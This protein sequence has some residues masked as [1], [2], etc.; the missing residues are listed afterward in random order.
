M[1]TFNIDDVFRNR[2]QGIRIRLSNSKG[3]AA[4]RRER[5]E[6]ASSPAARASV[7]RTKRGSPAT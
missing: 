1:E 7:D 3:L 4:T 2:Q 5:I 6:E